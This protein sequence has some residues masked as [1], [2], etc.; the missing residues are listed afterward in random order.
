MQNE[1][2]VAHAEDFFE[3]ARDHPDGHSIGSELVHE[4]VYFASCSDIHTAGWFVENEN[5][6]L[7][8]QPF[9]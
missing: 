7:A 5:A 4:G 6:R 1:D 3:I 2:A 9:A 8:G